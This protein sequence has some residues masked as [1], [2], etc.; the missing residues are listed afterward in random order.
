MLA[1]DSGTGTEQNWIR[2]VSASSKLS[3]GDATKIN[4]TT[5]SDISGPVRLFYPEN[6]SSRAFCIKY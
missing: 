2:R 3:Y 1:G 5:Q 6:V 4:D